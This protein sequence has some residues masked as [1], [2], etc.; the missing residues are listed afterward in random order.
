MCRSDKWLFGQCQPLSSHCVAIIFPSL[1]I[2]DN[3]KVVSYKKLSLLT[4]MRFVS[5]LCDKEHICTQTGFRKQ[6]ADCKEKVHF[7]EYRHG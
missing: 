3:L 7:G 2:L 1:K 4:L 6:W 5:E